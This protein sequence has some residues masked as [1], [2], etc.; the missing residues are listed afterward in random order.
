MDEAIRALLHRETLC[1]VLFE[2]KLFSRKQAEEF[3]REHGF[4]EPKLLEGPV[5]WRYWVREVPK[6][7]K[8][9]ELFRIAPG[10]YGLGLERGP[11]TVDPLPLG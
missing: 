2:R 3:L 6:G 8:Q 11:G 5:F 1:I 4:T 7:V 10:I 9:I